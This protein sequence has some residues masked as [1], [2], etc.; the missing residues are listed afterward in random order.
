MTNII[1]ISDIH[2][3]SQGKRAFHCLETSE[4]L[5]LVAAYLEHL[6]TTVMVDALVLS[7]DI[8]QDGASIVDMQEVKQLLNFPSL[9]LI[10]GNHDAKDVLKAV[11][12]E[13][14]E[15]F[16]NFRHD[17]PDCR[18]LG[19]DTSSHAHH[20]VLSPQTLA[21]LE[22]GLATDAPVL[23]FMHHP[24]V[25]AY[26]AFMDRN[27][28]GMNPLAGAL[29]RRNSEVRICCGHIHR[30]LV[31]AYAGCT[32][33]CCPSTSFELDMDYTSTG[34]NTYTE[35][36]ALIALHTVEKGYPITSQVLQVPGTYSFNR[37]SFL[38]A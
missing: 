19:L 38:S 17:F 30:T 15:D 24:P 2:Y 27:L 21:F 5:R 1:Q 31:T 16:P 33:F 34:G 25:K 10:P 13:G 12:F 11:T 18:I 29:Q 32:V 36:G 20:G 28:E 6:K 37:H 14:V 9:F 26:C 23:I 7:G 8:I 35:S 22:A 3:C 4:R